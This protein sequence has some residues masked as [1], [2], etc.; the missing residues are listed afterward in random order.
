M[1]RPMDPLRHEHSQLLP[2]IEKLRDVADSLGETQ[3]ES[4]GRTFAEVYDFLAGHL[5]PHAQAEERVLYP[6][7]GR[8]LGAPEATATMSRDHVEIALLVEELASLRP[9]LSAG[10]IDGAIARE[11]R[12]VLYALNALVKSHLAKEE[13]VY[14]PLLDA[15]LTIQEAREMFAGMEEAARE[16]GAQCSL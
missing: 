2:H 6:A 14:L 1:P 7:V 15:R 9:R 13:A 10:A 3:A 16:A 4:L 5:L 12:R 11:L 8:A